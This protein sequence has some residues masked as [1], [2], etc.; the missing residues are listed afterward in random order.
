MR[1]VPGVVVRHEE[2]KGLRASA[3]WLFQSGRGASRQL[4]RYRELRPPDL[5]FGGWLASLGVAGALLGSSHRR[6][7]PALPAAYTLAAGAA[8]VRQ[9]FDL[10]HGRPLRV[11]GAVLLDAALLTS[12][13]AGRLAGLVSER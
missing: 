11:A 1:T 6:L 13:F 10:D 5:A 7:A 4:R 12:Y 3:S 9:K 2:S 8:H